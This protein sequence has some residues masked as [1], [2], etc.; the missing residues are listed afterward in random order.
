MD[1][2]VLR[3]IA[4]DWPESAVVRTFTVA[5]P[6][7][8]TDWKF[9]VPGE[10]VLA[11]FSVTATLT[12]SAVVANRAPIAFTTDGNAILFRVGPGAAVTASQTV[13]FSWLPELG[14][15]DTATNFNTQLVGLPPLYMASG[16]VFQVATTAIDVGDQWSGIV[17]SAYEVF[18][19][20]REHERSIESALE[21]RAEAIDRILTGDF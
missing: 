18:H 4:D 15:R 20:K 17:I 12:A 1:P 16:Q 8:G 11:I 7:V 5:N 14:Y 21:D 19:G 9:T 3:T 2:R 6:G 13:I 10:S